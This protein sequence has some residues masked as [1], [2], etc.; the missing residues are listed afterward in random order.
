M[1]ILK[2]LIALLGL[3]ILVFFHELG[4][5]LIAKLF[6]IKVEVFSVGMGP[7]I[8]SFKRKETKYQIG[9][10]PFGGFCKFKGEELLDDKGKG[11]DPDS[12]YGVSPYKRLAV[13]FFG[14]FMNYI[15]A[16]IFLSI[17]FMGSHR[18][19]K[20][21]N[22]IVLA[23]D[24]I[25]NKTGKVSQAK[26]GGLESGD[27]ITKI[28]NKKINSFSDISNYLL[29]RDFNLIFSFF[30]KEKDLKVTVDR[31]GK[32]ITLNILPKWDPDAHRSIMGIYASV[33]PVI[34]TKNIDKKSESLENILGL[35]DG[36]TIIGIDDDY[37]NICEGKISHFL[38]TNFGKD[39]SSIL[40]V[41]RDGEV[42][43]IPIVFNEINHQMNERDFGLH[44]HYD[45]VKIKA[46][47]PF[48]AIYSGFNESNKIIKL[49]IMGL[50]TL[51]FKKNNNIQKDMG[52]PLM[53]GSLIGNV[54]VSGFKEGIYAG[55]RDFFSVI[56]YISLALAFFNLLPIPAVDGGHIILNLYEIITRKPISLKILSWINIFG[57]GILILFAI[58]VTYMDIL[59]LFGIG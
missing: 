12:F 14:P 55:L 19:I 40:H 51:I 9:Y 8:F 32:P 24:I 30:R 48:V 42:V 5:F 25:N 13:A 33:S 20:I 38:S 41:K 23:D 36:D 10:I 6:K 22:K 11:R 50:Y 2:I 59:K 52:G 29:M 28:G 45:Q 37:Q 47:N 44:F 1:I 18:E 53:I 34:D 7:A 56:S 17:L 49:S 46:Q 3:G 27:I 31:N 54:T 16:I 21:P 58:A 57:F 39:K 35:R 43:D 26:L 4:H 15:I